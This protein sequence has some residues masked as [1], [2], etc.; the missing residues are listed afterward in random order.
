MAGTDRVAS[1]YHALT[2]RDPSLNIRKTTLTIQQAFEA[3]VRR[4]RP[5]GAQALVQTS[6]IA[7]HSDCRKRAFN[8]GFLRCLRSGFTR[9]RCGDPATKAETDHNSG[10]RL[11]N[12]ASA[13]KCLEARP[14]QFKSTG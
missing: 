7:P 1:G 8:V 2:E 3:H 10:V 11:A 4:K 12:G 13:E 9:E 6:F 14:L 5:A